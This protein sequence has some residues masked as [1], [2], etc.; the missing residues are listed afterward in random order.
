MVGLW[1]FMMV[2]DGLWWFMALGLPHYIKNIKEQVSGLL[3]KTAPLKLIQ[4]DFPWSMW[5][6]HA[7]WVGLSNPPGSIFTKAGS[8]GSCWPADWIQMALEPGAE[9]ISPKV[10]HSNDQRKQHKWYLKHLEALRA[11]SLKVWPEHM[12]AGY[13]S[14]VQLCPWARSNGWSL[15]SASYLR[16]G[17][18]MV[19]II[20]ADPSGIIQ[21]RY[22]VG[23]VS[24]MTQ[25][26]WNWR[27]NEAAFHW[28]GWYGVIIQAPLAR[29]LAISWP[30]ICRPCDC[31]NGE[32]TRGGELL[33][34]LIW[35][36]SKGNHMFYHYILGFINHLTYISGKP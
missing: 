25:L 20:P 24:E 17:W 33:N 36:E 21:L 29:A 32:G 30:I 28:V 11:F 13:T 12:V 35:G 26:C 15:E 8:K 4:G 14:M 18:Q 19:I 1:W 5:S 9:G 7:T 16:R 22:S 27:V 23:M 34:R 6:H 10:G 3:L 31:Q 2:Y